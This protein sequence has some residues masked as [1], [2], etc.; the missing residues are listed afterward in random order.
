MRR[1]W[2]ILVA[3]VALCVAARLPAQWQVTADAGTAHLRQSGIPES[4]AFTF[5]TSVDA[6]G[7]RA[8][9][10]S[11]LLASRAADQ[12]WTG[13]GVVV[14]SVN[15][16]D[17][18][19]PNWELS[20]ALSDF[21]QSNA[22]STTSAEAMARLRL[23]ATSLGGAVGVGGGELSDAGGRRSLYRVQATA[24][25]TFSADQVV[26][27]MS[28]VGT[29]PN[30]ISLEGPGYADFSAG[31]RRVAGNLELGAT[32]GFRSRLQATQ[33]GGWGSVDATAWVAPNLAVVVAAGRALEDVPRGVPRTQYASITLRV[34]ARAQRQ[35]AFAPKTVVTRAGLRMTVDSA[36]RVELMADFTDW[37]VVLLAQDGSQWKLD[38]AVSPGLHRIAIRID[39]G[40]WIAP[41][42]LP[43]AV[44]DLGGVVGLITVP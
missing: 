44:D 18:T 43:R 26:A 13:Q 38:R 35:P 15:G 29:G 30:D 21:S 23:G 5:G 8:V 10:R 12:R 9:L 27:D 41:P 22:A 37:A 28:V 1:A 32:A 11:R 3:L 20:G 14:A 16:A 40:D 31:W 6:L 33:S 34:A 2:L 39:G 17:V 19:G 42:G 7:T 4:N 25:R 36:S 24:W